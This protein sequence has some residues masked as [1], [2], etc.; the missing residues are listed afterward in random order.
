MPVASVKTEAEHFDLKSLE[1][2]FVE[3]R[4]MS[5]GEKLTRNQNATEMAIERGEGKDSR[6]IIDLLQRET[7]E[8]EFKNLIVDHNL[9]LS[10]GQPFDFRQK[11][12]LEKLDPRVG[13]EI[14]TLIGK[15]NNFEEDGEGN[16]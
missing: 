6:T 11:G 13:E 16:G 14:S 1:G 5:F 12:M 10:E 7:A 15:L 9:E 8:W 2:A 3:L 4:R